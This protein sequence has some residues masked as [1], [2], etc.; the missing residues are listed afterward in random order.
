MLRC[1]QYQGWF[2]EHMWNHIFKPFLFM[3]VHLFPHQV[4]L[5]TFPKVVLLFFSFGKDQLQYFTKLEN[6]LSY[7][8]KRYKNEFQY[9]YFFWKESNRKSLLYILKLRRF[10][11]I[12]TKKK[13]IF[14]STYTHTTSGIVAFIFLFSSHSPSLTILKFSIIYSLT[15]LSDWHT[16]SFRIVR[17][18]LMAQ[19]VENLPTMKEIWV[20]P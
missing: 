13:S 1:H 2:I 15:Q 3:S 18:F 16:L 4:P 17:V 19:M 6:V 8:F 7:L 9:P 14:H 12:E 10:Y 5:N 11:W 20:Y